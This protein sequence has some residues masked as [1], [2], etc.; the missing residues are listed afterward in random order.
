MVHS[1][2]IQLPDA[3]ATQYWA[4]LLAA[5]LSITLEKTS[6]GSKKTVTLLVCCIAISTREQFRSKYNAQLPNFPV[7][8]IIPNPAIRGALKR[9]RGPNRILCLRIY[10]HSVEIIYQYVDQA[11]LQN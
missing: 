10:T 11:K 8:P 9:I 6:F 5:K 4:L 1:V 2:I 3:K 7:L